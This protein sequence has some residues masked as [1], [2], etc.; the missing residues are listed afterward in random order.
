MHSG[1]IGAA[2]AASLARHRSI[3]ISY[4]TL[5][6]SP[7]P[8][9][10]LDPAQ[11]LGVK[12][13][14]HLWNNWAKDS[15]G[16]VR[17][18]EVDLYSVNL[19]LVANLLTEESLKVYWTTVWRSSYHRLFQEVSGSKREVEVGSH[20]GPGAQSVTGSAV[21]TI[22][23]EDVSRLLTFKWSP[24]NVEPDLKD[25]PVG[26]DIWAVFQGHVSVNP[27]RAGYGEATVTELGVLEGKEEGRLWR[28]KI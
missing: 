14:Q 2:L 10:V 13:I 20:G 12:I 28:Y 7:P 1:T 19:P 6:D 25:V 11:V 5:V 17:D 27:M 22:N 16:G 9:S 15:S 26:T 24:D 3:A 23:P 21:K 8:G 18:G 4:G